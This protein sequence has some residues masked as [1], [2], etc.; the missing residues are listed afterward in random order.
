VLDITDPGVLAVLIEQAGA[1]LRNADGVRTY[2]VRRTAADVLAALQS[3]EALVEL[4]GAREAIA[5]ATDTPP[6]ETDRQL[7]ADLLS[8]ID[9]ALD[10]YFL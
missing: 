2:A 6:S 3:D 4:C 9:S 7:M 10:P 5:A 8:R 1:M